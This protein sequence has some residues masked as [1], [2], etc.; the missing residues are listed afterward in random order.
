MSEAPLLPCSNDNAYSVTACAVSVP[1]G[2]KFLARMSRNVRRLVLVLGS[3]TVSSR[4]N[5]NG[6]MRASEQHPQ[7]AVSLGRGRVRSETTCTPPSSLLSTQVLCR[8]LIF[9]L[10]LHPPSDLKAVRSTPRS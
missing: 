4:K 6:F 1:R 3:G 10:Y 8:S 5:P 9:Q 7:R 2:R